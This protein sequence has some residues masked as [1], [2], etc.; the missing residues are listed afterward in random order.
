MRT[1]LTGSRV[2]LRPTWSGT[3]GLMPHAHPARHLPPPGRTLRDQLSEAEQLG[4]QLDITM[5]NGA[6]ITGTP[7]D[8]G[9]DF[10]SIDTDDRTIDLALFHIVSLG[11]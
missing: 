1:T 2:L 10:V 5:A 6:C 8:V 4:Y 3:V 9:I 7:A 11:W